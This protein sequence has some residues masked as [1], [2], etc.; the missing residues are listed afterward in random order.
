MD[1][2]KDA[3]RAAVREFLSTR[4]ERVSP[5]DAGLPA[6]GTRRRVKG[7][8]REEVALLAGVS[9][10]YYIRLERGQA[11]SPSAGVVESIAAVLRLDDDERAHLGRLLAALTPE[12]RKRRRAP[13]KDSGKDSGKDTVS[14]G[15]R[16]LLDSIR[17][18]PAIVA[19]SRLD[20]LAANDLGRAFYAPMLDTDGPVNSARFVFL[21]E[22]AA[23]RLFPEWERIADDAVAMLR[24]ESGRHPDDPALVALIGQLSTRSQAFR[25]RWAAHDVKAH[26][27]G[28]KVFRQPLIGEVTLPFENLTVDAAEDQVLTVLTPQPGSPEHDAIQLL[29]S[30]NAHSPNPAEAESSSNT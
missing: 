28:T 14:P 7:L 30:W 1:E 19:N 10:E 11:T 22:H 8:R 26:R 20:I 4:R 3:A 27:A 23:R 2:K 21:E 25:T 29:A 6:T 24:I 15:I 9:P 17:H 12:A 5:A 13:G 18:L 16:V